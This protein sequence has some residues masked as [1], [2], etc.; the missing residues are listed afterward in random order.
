MFIETILHKLNDG[1]LVLVNF[2]IRYAL[3]L[4]FKIK[5]SFNLELV[6]CALSDGFANWDSYLIP[7]WLFE[8][9]TNSI[10]SFRVYLFANGFALIPIENVF[11][12]VS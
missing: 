7:D 12:K 5:R 10:V 3:R 1:K 2:P 6:I 4:Y 11:G 8:L 9:M